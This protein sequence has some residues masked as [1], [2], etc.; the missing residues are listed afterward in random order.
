MI[1]I[2]LLD[3]VFGGQ[4]LNHPMIPIMSICDNF[5]PGSLTFHSAQRAPPQ[6]ENHVQIFHFSS[7]NDELTGPGYMDQLACEQKKIMSICDSMTVK[8]CDRVAATVAL[9]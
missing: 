1:L 3:R 7:T 5:A 6:F 8:L 9:T 4:D 2:D